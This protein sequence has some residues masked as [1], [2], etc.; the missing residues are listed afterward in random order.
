[1]F[2]Y[3]TRCFGNLHFDG[4]ALPSEGRCTAFD[5]FDLRPPINLRVLA[6]C[7]NMSLSFFG[8]IAARINEVCDLVT[9]FQCSVGK[10]PEC[11]ALSVGR[12]GIGGQVGNFGL[13]RREF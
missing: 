2:D 9:R 3:G 8:S 1:M 13:E 10:L 6:D 11:R 5:R 12:G 7:S 4:I